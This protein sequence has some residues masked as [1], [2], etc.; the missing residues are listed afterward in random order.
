MM[1]SRIEGCFRYSPARLKVARAIVEL[2]LHVDE[3][4]TIRC[5]PIEIPP[6]KMAKALGVD[7]RVVVKTAEF[8]L[9]EPSL[10]E[11]FTKI[12]PAGPS[13]QAVAKLFGFGVVI[14]TADPKTV[15]IIAK[16][17]TLIANEGISIRQILAEDPELFPQPKL[18]IV[19]E[20]EVPSK[21]IP[22]FARIPGVRGV[23]IY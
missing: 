2:G 7:R 1:W 10:R 14:I 11:V 21:L 18:T 4:G 19:T 15:G 6:S 5:G 9:S 20:R 13:F 16:A 12:R 17:S 23:T 3:D 8:I 22:K